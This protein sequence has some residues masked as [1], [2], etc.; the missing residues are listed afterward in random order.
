MSINNEL[1]ALVERYEYLSDDAENAHILLRNAKTTLIASRKAKVEVYE[2]VEL[3]RI[4]YNNSSDLETSATLKDATCNTLNKLQNHNRDISE[5]ISLIKT[6]HDESYNDDSATDLSLAVCDTLEKI[7]TTDYNISD[8]ISLIETYSRESTDPESAREL[9]VA[10]SKTLEHAY[11]NK[12]STD[13]IIEKIKDVN[14]IER[15]RIKDEYNKTVENIKSQNTGL[16]K[17][18]KLGYAAMILKLTQPSFNSSELYN[19]MANN[20]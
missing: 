17:T 7:N 2:T 10:V 5:V 16:T 8:A 12:L 9:S 1:E 14:T 4:Y 13:S 19:R 11:D 18:F 3:I 6:Y 15:K 20:Q